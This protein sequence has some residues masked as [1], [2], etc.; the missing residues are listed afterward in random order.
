MT[1]EKKKKWSSFIWTVLILAACMIA[2][3]EFLHFVV[4]INVIVEE[5][6]TSILGTIAPILFGVPG[7]IGCIIGY[8]VPMII[9]GYLV[10]DLIIF[11]LSKII[12]YVLVF[13]AGKKIKNLNTKREFLSLSAFA[14][15][16]CFLSFV[17]QF[18]YSEIYGLLE[19]DGV[20]FH[21]M[22]FLTSNII[23]VLSIALPLCALILRIRNGKDESVSKKERK[24]LRN[25]FILMP[26][27]EVVSFIFFLI[28][29]FD[30][31]WSEADWFKAN[32]VNAGFFVS[33][34]V[35]LLL[36]DKWEKQTLIVCSVVLLV[37]LISGWI[38]KDPMIS[39]ILVFLFLLYCLFRIFFFKKLEDTA[40]IQKGWKTLC[41]ICNIFIVTLIIFMSVIVDTIIVLPL[42]DGT[43][44]YTIVLGAPVYEG[45]PSDILENRIQTAEAYC[46]LNPDSLYFLTGGIKKESGDV[47]EAAAIGIRLVAAGLDP[48]Q[49]ELECNA[50][51]TLENFQNILKIFEERGYDKNSRIALISSIFHYPRAT[52]YAHKAG[53]TNLSYVPTDYNMIS[54]F[55]W[56]LREAIVFPSFLFS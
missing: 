36:L 21:V 28:L 4:K 38:H 45:E 40:N 29:K 10:S 41:T 9:E 51:T 44:K 7:I 47:S 39:L 35:F 49:I 43:E 18:Y 8:A 34:I 55:L 33:L 19:E 56:S 17:V 37:V 6:I 14:V 50:K 48:E 3:M 46:M 24:L 31:Y 53:F 1:S 54:N 26:V 5:W 12:L 20:M 52:F 25:I 13:Y 2:G 23:C 42:S 22:N 32:L 15:L 16:G 27:Y 30:Q 11:T